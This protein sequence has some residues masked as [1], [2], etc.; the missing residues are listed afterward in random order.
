MSLVCSGG[1]LF[2]RRKF[3]QRTFPWPSQPGKW[4]C[5]A[6]QEKEQNLVAWFKNKTTTKNPAVL[7]R[8]FFFFLAE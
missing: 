6:L 4:L 3:L 2:L 1:Q 7:Q 5:D 8:V